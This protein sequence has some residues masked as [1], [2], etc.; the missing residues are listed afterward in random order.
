MNLILFLIIG[1]VAGWLAGLIMKGRGFGVLA[2]VS[3]IR[4]R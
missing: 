1:G 3:Q 4:K 2:I